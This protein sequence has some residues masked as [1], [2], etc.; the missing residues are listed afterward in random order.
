MTYYMPSYLRRI[1][2]AALVDRCTQASQ[3]E[4]R[5]FHPPINVQALEDGYLVTSMVPGLDTQDLTIE[6]LKNTLTLRGEFKT[7]EN[8]YRYLRNELP[9]GKFSRTLTFPTELDAAKTK[10]E[11]KNG[12]LSIHILKSEEHRPKAIKV[13][14]S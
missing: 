2:P 6:I 13:K 3:S 9:Q 1:N 5:Q 12:L 11:I 14:A 8:D 10:A 7:E 4:N